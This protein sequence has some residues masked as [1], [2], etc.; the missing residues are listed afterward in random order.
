MRLGV[1]G[2]TFDPVHVGHLVLAEQAR[3]QLRLGRVLWVPAGDPW[4]K[5]GAAVTAAGHRLAMV[6]LAIA[7]NDAFEV[8]TAE[9]D[10]SGPTYTVDTLRELHGEH[11]AEELTFLLGLDALFDLPNG[12]EPAE[13]I[14]L[15]MLGVAPRGDHPAPEE[16]ERL[17][18][19][20]SE[21]LRWVE[22]PRLDVSG[23]ELRRR[24]AAGQTLRY[25]VPPEVEAYIEEHRLYRTA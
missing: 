15:A 5:P 21:R 17:L 16:L 3:E 13:L 4:R 18:P 22:M 25:L 2:G 20:L 8:T 10:R 7:G 24:A 14:R 12:H 23:T 9:L 19:G 6:R 11:A 1:L